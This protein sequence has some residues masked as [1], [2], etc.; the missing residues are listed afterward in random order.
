MKEIIPAIIPE[1]FFDLQGK[2]SRVI[3]LAPL[4]QI[5]VLDGKLTPEPSWPYNVEEDKNFLEIT[6]GDKGFP[7]WEKLDFEVDLMVLDPFTLWED[8]FNA[9]AKRI[10]FHIESKT[11]WE[12]LIAEFKKHSVEKDLPFYTELGFA[13]NI[14]T[15]LEKLAPV[16]SHADFIQCMG[17]ARIGFQG[18]PF[19]E[20]VIEKIKAIKSQYSEMIIS[21]DGGVSLDNA[22]ALLEA[23]ATRLVS[24]SA[25]FEDSDISSAIGEFRNLLQ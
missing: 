14:D 11:N 12:T 17:I 9:G 24:G 21:V 5:D 13:I 19:D 15:P 4:V 2:M 1:D 25:I 3:G 16:I 6:H 7:Y 23:G 18:E 10:I 8:W 20:R 22:S